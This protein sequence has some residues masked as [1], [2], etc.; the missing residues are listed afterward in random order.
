MAVERI[1]PE[2]HALARTLEKVN[3][4]A[5][6]AKVGSKRGARLQ[7]EKTEVET[8]LRRRRKMMPDR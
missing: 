1:I 6:L 5:G 8:R 4:E 7:A 3:R 2:E